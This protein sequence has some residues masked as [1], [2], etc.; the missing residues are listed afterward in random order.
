MINTANN[1]ITAIELGESQI[2]EFKASFQKEVI[3][4]VVAFANASGGKILIGVVE[5]VS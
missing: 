5:M 2:T 1:L 4:T 3:E